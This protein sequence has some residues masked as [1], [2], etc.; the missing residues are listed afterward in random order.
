MKKYNI[1][2]NLIRVIKNLYDKATSAVLFNGSIGDWFRT[3]VGVRQ[4]CLLSPTLFNI[5]VERIMT[6][7]LED[8]EGTVN[9]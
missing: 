1:N 3:T 5:F 6:D 8:H 4:G 9:I 2:A 7:A